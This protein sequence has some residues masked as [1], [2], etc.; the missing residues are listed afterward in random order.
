MCVHILAVYNKAQ[1]QRI[2]NRR[3]KPF[4]LFISFS[5]EACFCFIINS[6]ICEILSNTTNVSPTTR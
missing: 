1:A 4:R 2:S 3:F 5:K 6:N